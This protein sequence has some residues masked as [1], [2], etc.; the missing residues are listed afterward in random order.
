VTLLLGLLLAWP[1]AGAPAGGQTTP[2]ASAGAREGDR[3]AAGLATA[4]LE[5]EVVD[6]TG[7][8]LPAASV[9]VRP[10][11][12]AGGAP[13][14]SAGGAAGGAPGG[15]PGSAPGG[16]A[17]RDP[18][19]GSQAPASAAAFE[20]TT[21]EAGTA[22]LTLVP[23]RYDLTVSLDGFEPA[24]RA[25]TLTARQD[26]RVRVELSLSRLT[27]T[28]T[29]GV[30]ASG[31]ADTT[32]DAADIDA[33]ADDPEALD[34]FIADL[35]GPEAEVRVDGFSGGRT[36]RKSDVAQIVVISDPYSA[37]FHTVGQ[38]QVNVVTKPGFGEW[39]G[40]AG[41]DLATRAMAARDVFARERLDYRRAGGWFSASGPIRR[42][43]TSVSIDGYLRRD[44]QQA[45][46]VALTSAG[47]LRTATA[48]RDRSQSVEVRF[49]TAVG[50]A[51]LRNRVEVE[52]AT[53]SGAGVGD[54]DLPERAYGTTRQRVNARSSL[55]S[56]IGYGIEQD[57]RLFGS[58]QR[59]TQVPVTEARTILVL[60]AFRAGGAQTRGETL[61]RTGQVEGTWTLPAQ[62]G[63]RVRT[64]LSLDAIR[65]RS[66]NLSNY[67]GTW[68]FANL[69]AYEAGRPITY[70]QRIGAAE[71]QVPDLRGAVYLHDQIRLRPTLQAGVGLRQEWQPAVNRPTPA[72]RLSLAWVRPKGL[73]V[74]GGVGRFFGWYDSG[75]LEEARRLDGTRFTEIILQSPGYPDPLGEGV[76][77]AAPPSTRV[78][79]APDVTLAS[80]W[81]AS[82]TVER[83]VGTVGLRATAFRQTG[84]RE[85]RARN[86]NV[87]VDGVRPDPTLGNVLRISPIGRSE[88]LGLE[89]GVNTGQL[90]RRRLQA[91]VNYSLGRA[92]ND[93][94]GALSLP[95]DSLNPTL[96]WGP[97]RNDLRHRVH[98]SLNLKGGGLTLNL[99]TRAQSGQ[100]Y[101]ITT[102][103][104]DNGDT[105]TN[106]RPAGLARN[107]GRGNGRIATDLRLSWGRKLGGSA[108]A[109][110]DGDP[111][112]RRGGQDLGVTL[113]AAN[114]FNQRQNAGFSGVLTSP[115]FGQPTSAL[116]ARRLNLSMQV[117]F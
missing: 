115:L 102:G 12:A 19:A 13:G 94:D 95:A 76:A 9:T 80:F 55:T 112:R 14:G 29:V 15:A 23:G 89:L 101:N 49:T 44:S 84:G 30:T 88:S 52:T 46:S 63:L 75:L 113:S 10:R 87:P 47:T 81:R 82:V 26:Q 42:A 11:G 97:G 62:R 35:A 91:S 3:R 104:D 36:P 20:R 57:L 98:G 53:R 38:S 99:Y 16:G 72:P 85:P 7:G 18:E 111:A 34:A 39:H 28:V 2:P 27:E 105:V 17:R 64:G 66:T 106:D 59:D 51:L 40:W 50:Q 73:T 117:G 114:V 60:G 4:T 110:R 74:R 32:V 107:A 69:E 43:R 21:G 33:L 8:L 116:T 58:W 22:R 71:V 67:L 61:V 1:L 108:A 109:R 6:V 5:V 65:R 24:T 90:W 79:A 103:Q 37:Q 86:V 48:V 45:P 78:I 83:K 54:L 77:Q 56:T 93:A 70:T 92:R 100:P 68:V 96:E 25:L 31:V 41:T